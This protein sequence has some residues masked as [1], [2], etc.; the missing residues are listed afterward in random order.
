MFYYVDTKSWA[1]QKH[2]LTHPIQSSAIATLIFSAIDV[3]QGAPV[4]SAMSAGSLGTYFGGIYC[5]HALQCPMEAIHGRPSLWHNIISGG[6]IGA[7]GVS[8]GRL[9]IPLLGAL[10]PNIRY[11]TS[12]PVLAFG[13]Y[14]SIS[15]I[16]GGVL[17]SKPF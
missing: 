16:L 15:G 11:G 5:Y 7:L 9:G 8:S 2:C 10:P 13:V 1:Y 14:G 3:F 17:G 6:T 12:P 4:K